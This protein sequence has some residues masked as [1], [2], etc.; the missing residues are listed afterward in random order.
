[1]KESCK[2]INALL[3]YSKTDKLALHICRYTIY[4][5]TKNRTH[6]KFS[7]RF[8]SGAKQGNFGMDTFNI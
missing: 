7:F 4:R 5:V 8:P 1:M 2:K 6:N 3:Y